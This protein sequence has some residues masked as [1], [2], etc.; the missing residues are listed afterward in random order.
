MERTEKLIRNAVRQALRA[1]VNGTQIAMWVLEEIA[2]EVNYAR[3]SRQS[4]NDHLRGTGSGGGGP[5]QNVR[6]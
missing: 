5:E 3:T 2:N 6:F 4:Q 1:G